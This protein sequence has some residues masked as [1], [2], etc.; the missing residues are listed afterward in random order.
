[1][2]RRIPGCLFAS[3]GYEEKEEAQVRSRRA[4]GLQEQ[5]DPAGYGKL[6]R[7]VGFLPQNHDERFVQRNEQVAKERLERKQNGDL[8][9]RCANDGQYDEGD[10]DL[11]DVAEENNT[12]NNKPDVEESESFFQ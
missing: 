10:A 6:D 7:V 8:D 3:K 12:N 11:S 4:G 5:L 1:M 2:L 9:E